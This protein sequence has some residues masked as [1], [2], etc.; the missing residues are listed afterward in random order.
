M[1]KTE[2]DA[3][4]VG[5]GPNGLAA[6]ITLAKNG[7]SVLVLEANSTIG[8]AARSAEL[9]RPG[10]V[11]DLGS[12]IH[13][14]AFGS[15]FFRTLPLQRHGLEWIQPPIALAHPLDG[16]S[17][18]CLRQDLQETNDSLGKDERAWRRLLQPFVRDWEKLSA[19]FLRP[20]LH[21]PRHPLA[22]ARFGLPALAPAAALAKFRFQ[23]APAR[24]LFAGI[25][26]H[27]FLP[28]E[29]IASAAFGLVLGAAGHAVGWPL[30]RGGAQAIS[31][32]LGA[33][34]RELGGEIETGRRIENLAQLPTARAVLF[35]VTCWQLA[36]LAAEQLPDRYRRRLEDFRHAPGVFK[37]DYALSAPVPWLAPECRAA[38]T[39]HL[40]GALEEI[41]ASEREVA[42]GRHA[43][44][45]FV[46]VAQQSLFDRTRAPGNQHTL[47]AYCHVP[48]SSERDMTE[49]IERQ[50]ERF[51][52]GF[53]DCVL[54]RQTSAASALERSNA[55]LVGGDINGGAADLW[56]LIARPVVSPAPYRTPRRGLYLCSSSTPPGGGVHGMCG[57]H[58]A[59][60]ALRDIFGKRIPPVPA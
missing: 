19:E 54:A 37:I 20:M 2:Y 44:R 28:L 49:A 13:P 31:D 3:V 6:A 36:R 22:L 33:H 5:S 56:Q 47:W 26:A 10:F 21:L 17:A 39:L 18:A 14:L 50:L 53:R 9:T 29:A 40:G 46:L 24:A 30:P 11:H 38:G 7:C 41:A 55:N 58:A 42:Q 15:P 16:G 8:G 23:E 1:S 57:Y 12:A 43:E 59:R 51:A 52:P 4:V 27:S 35:D 34:L 32:A 48:H 25:A 45:P 60:T